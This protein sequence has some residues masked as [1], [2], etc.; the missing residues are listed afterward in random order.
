MRKPLVQETSDRPPTIHSNE[1]GSFPWSVLHDRHPELI[2]RVLDSNP[3]PPRHQHRLR[4][5]LEQA[6]GGVIEPLDD[7]AGDHERWRE[8]ARPYLG[9]RWYDVPWLWAES[10]FYRKVLAA[11]GYYDPGP[12]QGVDPFAPI[13][14]AELRGA[15]VEAE[16]AG[17][18]ELTDLPDVEVDRAVLE[19][20]LWGNRADLGFRMVADGATD[21]ATDGAT[22]GAT[23]GTIVDDSARLWSLLDPARPGKVCV[24]ADNAAQELLPDLILVDHLLHSGRADVV[25]LHVK[26]YPYYVSDATTADTLACLRRLSAAHGQ[27]SVRGQRL[28]EAIRT[29]RLTLATHPFWC[30]PLTF[31]AMPGDLR[32]NFAD[33]SLTIV[34][35]DL[36]YRRL[37]DDR[38][39][40][41]TTPFGE[42]AAYFPSAVAALRILKSDVVAGLPAPAVETLDATSDDWRTSGSYALIQVRS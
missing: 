1:P 20:A 37:V 4:L 34:K 29:G 31:H 5:L 41:P 42:L 6:T 26:P 40:A 3:Y 7:A 2:R 30:A 19:A 36:N 9:K 28:A 12:W 39:W 8:W 10:Y 38:V 23:P 33:A 16:L 15:G 27:A 18:D 21:A 11:V 14:D 13:K 32:A 35:G 24:I 25:V 17:L 22:D